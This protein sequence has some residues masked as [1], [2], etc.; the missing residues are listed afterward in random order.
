[1]AQLRTR[2]PQSTPHAQL[3][4]SCT[5][6]MRET[7]RRCLTWTSAGDDRADELPFQGYAHQPARANPTARHRPSQTI[8]PGLGLGPQQLPK[9]ASG[10]SLNPKRK[11]PFL[12]STHPTPHS[13]FPI[14]HSPFPIPDSRFPIPDS[15]FPNPES[16]IP[17]PESRIP[18]PESRIP[19]LLQHPLT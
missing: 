2:L 4:C 15:R 12:F 8:R 18:N 9:F 16:R 7:S 13:P 6:S 3:P 11:T 5:I 19:N 17:N 1:M 14:P 10:C